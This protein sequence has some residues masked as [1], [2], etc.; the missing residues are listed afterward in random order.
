MPIASL[1]QCGTAIGNTHC[2]SQ[3]A[4]FGPTGAPH[5]VDSSI[6]L[7]TE[8]IVADGTMLI[9]PECGLAGVADG[10]CGWRLAVLHD[11]F[12]QEIYRDVLCIVFI[13]F[14]PVAAAKIIELFK[15]H[16]TVLDRCEGMAAGQEFIG[17]PSPW[18]FPQFVD[19]VN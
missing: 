11:G 7:G 14:N 19:R 5:G 2:P 10:D 8:L 3:T 9:D 6:D 1:I 15:G 4:L 16:T 18:F 17:V 12:T 13:N